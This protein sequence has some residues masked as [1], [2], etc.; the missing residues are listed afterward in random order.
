M[1]RYHGVREGG[2]CPRWRRKEEEGEE[3]GETT[4]GKEHWLAFDIATDEFV[5][6]DEKGNVDDNLTDWLI[7]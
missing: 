1:H 7:D 4:Y 6:V 3:E 2:D 5:L